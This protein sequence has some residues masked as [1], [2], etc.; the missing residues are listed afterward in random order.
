MNQRF[1]QT[2]SC[3]SGVRLYPATFFSSINTCR[4]YSHSGTSQ[5]SRA[6]K[7]L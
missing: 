1:L 2:Q 5:D 6:G 3:H 7:A 4:S